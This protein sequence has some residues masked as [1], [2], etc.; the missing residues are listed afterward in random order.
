[1]SAVTS[2]RAK[3]AGLSRSRSATDPEYVDA[4]R[5]LAAAKLESA[6]VKIV[7]DAP[8]L[9]DAQVA[10]LTVALIRGGQR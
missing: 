9:T 1:M 5:D 6:I 4:R 2:A 7:A 10:H 8:P 3:L